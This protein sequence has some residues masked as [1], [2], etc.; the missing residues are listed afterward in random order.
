MAV[1]VGA[2]FGEQCVPIFWQRQPKTVSGPE[3][4][5]I[6]DLGGEF[7]PPLLVEVGQPLRRRAAFGEFGQCAEALGQLGEDGVVV[8][9][10]AIGG[11][12]FAYRH[13]MCVA[14]PAADV[15]AFQGAKV[16]VVGSTI[17]ACLAV[18]VQY[19]S[20]TTTVSGRAI[21]VRSRF[22]SWWWNGLP[23]AQYTNRI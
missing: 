19:G 8:P 9:G 13:D 21:A 12:G 22:R 23:P 14:A 2:E 11:K 3:F 1:R 6:G 20:C 15:V 18:A 7:L 5:E 10:F 17:S 4:A 16:I